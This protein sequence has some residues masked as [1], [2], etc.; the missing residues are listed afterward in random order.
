MT[1]VSC[2]A[3]RGRSYPKKPRL[4]RKKISCPAVSARTQHKGEL[5]SKRESRR[6]GFPALAHESSAKVGHK[7]RTK[8]PANAMKKSKKVFNRPPYDHFFQIKA[9]IMITFCDH[10]RF[11]STLLNSACFPSDPCQRRPLSGQADWSPGIL[12]RTECR[13]QLRYREAD[14]DP[15]GKA[16]IS[17]L[18][19]SVILEAS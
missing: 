18:T 6:Q 7:R 13:L 2:T 3:K 8:R 10:F 4:R 15:Y 9:G 12:S 19:P 1:R 11:I 17:H 5:V 16:R 14:R